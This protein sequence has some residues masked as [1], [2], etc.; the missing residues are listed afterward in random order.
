M[1][2]QLVTSSDPSVGEKHST[3]AFW[4]E[5]VAMRRPRAVIYVSDIRRQD[6]NRRLT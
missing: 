4:E 1:Y 3:S 2:L 6:H 5:D